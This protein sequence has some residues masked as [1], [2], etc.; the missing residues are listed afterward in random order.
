MGVE[1]KGAREL[2][3]TMAEAG[4]EMHQLGAV[5][6]RVA[7][8]IAGA[9]NPPRK[10]GRLAA[11]IAATGEPQTATVASRVPYAGVVEWGWRARNIRGQ[12]FLLQAAQR[13]QPKWF[14]MYVDEIQTICDQVRGA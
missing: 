8:V 1:V 6:Q 13:T 10:T 14:Q 4:V 12:H 3:R 2:R 5:H 11:S 7:R 9:C